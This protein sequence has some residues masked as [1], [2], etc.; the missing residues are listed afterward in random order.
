MIRGFGFRPRWLRGLFG[1]PSA[2]SGSEL[3]HR[4]AI[5]LLNSRRAIACLERLVSDRLG[6]KARHLGGSVLRNERKNPEAEII[7]D[8][9]YSEHVFAVSAPIR[10]GVPSHLIKDGRL[11]L[12]VKTS[13]IKAFSEFETTLSGITDRGFRI[14]FFFGATKLGRR[15]IAVWE[16]VP[17]DPVPF[18]QLPPAKR[19]KLARAAAGISSIRSA[20][21]VPVGVR[22]ALP[23]PGWL[24]QIAEHVPPEARTEQYPML[25]A[26][27]KE[28]EQVRAALASLG[29]GS[30]AHNDYGQKNVTVPDHGD[31]VVI[32]WEGAAMSP[33]GTDLRFLV[34]RPDR[35][36]AERY[37]EQLC[38]YGVK[39]DLAA[40][41]AAAEMVEGF[42][43]VRFGSEW[44]QWPLLYRGAELLSKYG[45]SKASTTST[46]QVL[47]RK[48]EMWIAER[49]ALFAPIPHP[50]F[51][52]LPFRTG[53]EIFDLIAPH[54]S[55]VTALDIR[56]HWGYLSHRLE[57]AGFEVT[58]CEDRAQNLRFLREIRDFCG[59]RF[60]I[61]A[62]P[63]RN[64]PD[65]DFDIVIALNVFHH[66]LKDRS[67]FAA[68]DE[69]LQKLKCRQMIYQGHRTGGGEMKE[70]EIR[71]TSAQL[72]QYLS[73]RLGLPQVTSIGSIRGR[74][75]F[76]LSA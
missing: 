24:M 38:A 12:F 19:D 62:G 75:I 34:R 2:G 6:A 29:T 21:G 10:T 22:F 31:P 50:A 9:S 44:K 7:V 51:A 58:S 52:D 37:T 30:L 66:S 71:M 59:K 40:V 28:E 39:T 3:P 27:A 11:R 68:L 1:A 73:Q 64:I 70:A 13:P 15:H 43:S 35:N 69:F 46:E 23:Q 45:G 55:G 67:G 16:W 54:L 17:L 8:R 76:K 25:L 33:P 41:L 61:F 47:R 60:R 49:G 32:D 42:R 63:A 20:P 26:L 65:P 5:A 14:P 48:I 18:P 74:E 36:F 4:H 57:D 56:S 72:A 53:P